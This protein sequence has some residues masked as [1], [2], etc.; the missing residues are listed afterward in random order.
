ML[1]GVAAVSFGRGCEVAGAGC[2]VV[3]AT[4]CICE[5]RKVILA[6]I[7]PNCVLILC[8]PCSRASR[9]AIPSVGSASPSIGVGFRGMGALVGEQGVVCAESEVSEPLL[10]SRR[11]T[12]VG[13]HR[14]TVQ[15]SKKR[16][17]YC[18]G[19]PQCR[20]SSLR[21]VGEIQSILK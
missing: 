10:S 2:E 11:R 4:F 21:L 18:K 15:C 16:F 6:L 3:D 14:S 5:I 12:M 7:L 19:D 8:C 13:S 9:R 17:I 20:G 1:L